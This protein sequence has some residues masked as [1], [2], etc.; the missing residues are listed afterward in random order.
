MVFIGKTHA[1][2]VSIYL[3]AFGGVV[4]SICGGFETLTKQ[5]TKNKK[6]TTQAKFW[7][8]SAVIII[9][10]VFIFIVLYKNSNPIFNDAVN[11]ID[12][13]F[14]DVGFVF[15]IFV[16][17][18]FLYNITKPLL[19]KELVTIE[20]NTPTSL[21]SPS[22]EFSVTLLKKLKDEHLQASILI[23]TLNVL[24]ICFLL[25]DIL[26][27]QNNEAMQAFKDNVH[28]SVYTLIISIVFAI[29]IISIYFRGNINFYKQNN[30]LK[31]ITYGWLFLNTLLVLSTLYKNYYY[32]AHHGLT[33]KR[34]G[35]FVY[36]TLVL[37]GLFFTFQKIRLQKS[38]WFILKKSTV[39][40]FYLF[41][42]LSLVPYGKL[43]TYYNL[44]HN[45]V[46]D[47]EYLLSLPK[48]NAIILWEHKQTIKDK[49]GN[50]Y[51]P[52]L[53][54]RTQHY[55]TKLTKQNWQSTSLDNII[56]KP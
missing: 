23:A 28:N 51:Y 14:I 52:V 11:K 21:L 31:K 49:T 25:T 44:T 6:N 20:D 29:T 38:F 30:L 46:L 2:D 18:L 56:Y 45:V 10:V 5:E 13:S 37:V 15:T 50:D 34:I 24:L 8:L 42:I 41:A 55:K 32:V 39:I 53:L 7:L 9:P 35:V 16:A 22:E 54:E 19:I 47:V 36:L 48:D 3:A 43:V 4:D 1:P 33:Y 17:F 40:G 26:L 12:L 27:F